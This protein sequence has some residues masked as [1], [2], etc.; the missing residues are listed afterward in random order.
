M[1]WSQLELFE[2]R[3]RI[4]DPSTSQDAAASVKSS[5]V[6]SQLTTIERLFAVAGATGLTDEELAKL[7]VLTGWADSGIRT[8][9]SVLSEMAVLAHLG[10]TRPTSRGRQARVWVH[11][12]HVDAANARL[13]EQER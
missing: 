11:A 8:R 7:L 3:A 1:T 5:T 2:V 9:R 6:Q 10:E 4:D 12:K 13:R